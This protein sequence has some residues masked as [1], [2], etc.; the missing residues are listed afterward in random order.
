M[1]GY[2]RGIARAITLVRHNSATPLY[3]KGDFDI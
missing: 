2:C 3:W 1:E